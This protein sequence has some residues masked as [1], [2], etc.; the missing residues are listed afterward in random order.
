MTFKKI[1]FLLI[2]ILLILFLN[3][4]Q[5]YKKFFV[6][7][8]KDPEKRLIDHHGYCGGE[9]VGFIKF[10]YKK[11]NFMFIPKILNFDKMVP[12]NYWSI[13]KFDKDIR[14]N[15][16]NYEYLILLNYNSYNKKNI[17]KFGK[18][19]IDLNNYKI[20]ENNQNCFLLKLT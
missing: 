11:Y 14:S 7:L 4:L 16:F 10:L 9:S 20:I 1:S 6:L 17:I 13:F 15:N 3:N 8:T 18:K 19:D 2:F 12:D 5:I